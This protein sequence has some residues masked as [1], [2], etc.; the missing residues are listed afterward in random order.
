MSMMELLMFLRHPGS[1]NEYWELDDSLDARTIVQN[2]LY[3][4]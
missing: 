3:S 4:R 2:I 1:T